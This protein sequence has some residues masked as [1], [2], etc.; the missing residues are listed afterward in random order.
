MDGGRHFGL[1]PTRDTHDADDVSLAVARLAGE[2]A[3]PAATPEEVCEHV[4]DAALHSTAQDDI[5]LVVARVHG[6]DASHVAA[7]DVAPDP[8]QVGE[9]RD[10][11]GRQLAEWGWEELAFTSELIVSELVTNAIRYGSPPIR[12]LMIRQEPDTL[13][14]EVSDGSSTSPHL[15]HART[16]DEGGRGLFLIA[17]VAH[18]W[19][20]RYTASGK[21]IWAEQRAGGEEPA[22][23]TAPAL[24]GGGGGTRGVTPGRQLSVQTGFGAV[25]PP[26]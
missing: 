6:L 25:L 4:V 13:I 17:Q 1:G 19:G 8:A 21:T 26:L 9:A 3:R 20:T 22:P 7:W 18:R 15:R 23:G 2:L 14:C 24:G 5:A 10:L 12:L 11:A 16:T